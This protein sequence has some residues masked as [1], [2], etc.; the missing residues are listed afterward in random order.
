MSFGPN[1]LSPLQIEDARE[2]AHRAS[3]LQRAVEDRIRETSRALAEAERS[4]RKLLSERILRL[5]ADGNAITACETI[6]KG[7]PDVADLRYARD[8]ARGIHDASRQE[9][10]RRGADRADVGRLLEWSRARDLRTDAEPP[11][12]GFVPVAARAA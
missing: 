8:L 9:A 1:V 2:A 7:M 10:F 11:A 4:Y 12:H 6:A 5:K 3:E